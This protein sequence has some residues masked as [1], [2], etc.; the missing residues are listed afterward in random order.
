MSV[1]D[2]V[3]VHA[4]NRNG[5]QRTNVRGHKLDGVRVGLSSIFTVAHCRSGSACTCNSVFF[6]GHHSGTDAQGPASGR[7]KDRH[8]RG[9]GRPDL[10]L[11]RR[12]GRVGG[13][14]LQISKLRSHTRVQDSL[15]CINISRSNT[16]GGC[17]D[18][19][20]V[21]SEQHAQAERTKK[22]KREG[23]SIGH[24]FKTKTKTLRMGAWPRAADSQSWS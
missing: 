22:R 14:G 3:H 13:W 9:S 24:R 4:P 7:K 8:I 17:E 23:A 19:V 1:C 10:A 18:E 16:N 5:I 20:T 15:D 12:R 11:T 21:T 6:P 2:S